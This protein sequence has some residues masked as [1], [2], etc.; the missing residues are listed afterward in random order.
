M[1]NWSCAKERYKVLLN[2]FGLDKKG[3]A[4]EMMPELK[5]EQ[6]LIGEEQ[7]SIQRDHPESL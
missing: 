5:D 7:W 1:K 2:R 6:E 4:E 3:F